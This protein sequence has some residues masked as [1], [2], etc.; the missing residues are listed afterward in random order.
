MF[1]GPKINNILF[2]TWP[3]R[4][5]ICVGMVRGLDYLHEDLQPCIIHQNIKASNI[6]LHKNFNAKIVNFGLAQ[7]YSDDESQLFT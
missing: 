6:L 2:L 5:K 3:I 4:F 7:L 1:V